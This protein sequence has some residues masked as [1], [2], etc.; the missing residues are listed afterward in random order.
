MPPI[1]NVVFDGTDARPWGRHIF[2]QDQPYRPTPPVPRYVPQLREGRTIRD[3]LQ[4]R[5]LLL[6]GTRDGTAV[7][8]AE[9]VG[10]TE[11]LTRCAL[12]RLK[13][14][15]EVEIVDQRANPSA[16]GRGQRTWL[17]VYGVRG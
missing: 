9:A 4:V 7:E 13:L 6:L 16:G 14:T 12:T 17:F 15:G 5:I 10:S 2:A 1:W 8:I 3:G 11:E